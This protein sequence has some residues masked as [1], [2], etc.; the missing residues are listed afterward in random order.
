MTRWLIFCGLLALA[1]GTFSTTQ[2]MAE[3]ASCDSGALV[4]SVELCK[5]F[6]RY[7][8]DDSP[9]DPRVQQQFGIDET[10][11]ARSIAIVVAIDH[12]TMDGADIP[13]AKV[14]GD[15]LTHFLVDNQKFD[16]VIVLRNEDATKDRIEYFLSDYVNA[17]RSLY[18]GHTRVLFAYSGHGTPNGNAE[19]AS[20]VLSAASSNAD[21]PNLFPLSELN[22][23][24]QQLS[25]YHFQSLSLINACYGGD[26]FGTSKP[27][28]NLFVSN[29]T[30]AHAL[31]AGSP[32]ELVWSLPGTTSGSI[33]F[34]EIIKGVESGDADKAN[35][36]LLSDGSGKTFLV[37][38]YIIRLGNLVSYLTDAV[39]DLGMNPETKQSYGVPWLGSVGTDK[40]SIGAFFFLG[41]ENAQVAGSSA[42][43][44]PNTIVLASASDIN[45]S[46][47]ASFKFD[48]HVTSIPSRPDIKVF[49]PPE[50]YE[51][52]GLDISH[53][54]AVDWAKVRTHATDFIYI[55][56]TGIA[57]EDKKFR[58][59][60]EGARQ[61]HIVRGAY[62]Y[63]GVC[64]EPEK[65]YVRI[66][67]VVELQKGDL[68]IAIDVDWP[69]PISQQAKCAKELGEVAVA[70]RV[71]TLSALLKEHYGRT[72]V[73]YGN[74]EVFNDL[75]KD[76][77]Q[78]AT[79]WLGERDKPMPEGKLAGT[80]PWIFW[81]F[82]EKNKTPGFQ[83]Q[84]DA[85]VFFGNS[86]QF[87]DFVD[88]KDKFTN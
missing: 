45:K 86:A 25:Q 29:A 66:A 16:E 53:F 84:I 62:H 43:S 27:G 40:P 79:I 76:Q 38:V 31:T 71:V 80:T 42:S 18:Q 68:P 64:E 13:P 58:E 21:L 41:P 87:K 55:R 17:Q 50:S 22:Q 24:L 82:T 70:R 75:L 20:L 5:Y 54:N 11:S 57:G 85:S 28:G 35:H 30:G 32:N 9:V 34:D 56:A 36:V 72:P 2:V 49:N 1:S 74:S 88:G 81:Q 33:F 44:K 6:I 14:D 19:G 4:R 7:K 73:I 59:N 8:N 47:G 15:N 48:T 65:Q 78:S 12:Y 67:K 37:P 3:D 60:W 23:K 83:G 46:L 10:T 77:L 61:K 39:R 51:V 63:F 52:R 26:L 69:P